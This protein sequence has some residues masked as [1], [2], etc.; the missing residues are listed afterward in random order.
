MIEIA[1]DESMS[2]GAVIIEDHTRGVKFKRGILAR[3]GAAVAI[4]FVITNF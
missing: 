1:Y 4:S 2:S 3:C